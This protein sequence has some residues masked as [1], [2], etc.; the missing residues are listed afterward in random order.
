MLAQRNINITLKCIPH[1]VYSELV[2]SSN[3]TYNVII[4]TLL[5]ITFL[6]WWQERKVMQK[7]ALGWEG[8]QEFDLVL[9]VLDCRNMH[10]KLKLTNA[11]LW[12]RALM[13]ALDLD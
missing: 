13:R 11:P 9:S 5:L 6:T 10:I 7:A 1:L 3:V 4:F 12:Q 2:P 8:L